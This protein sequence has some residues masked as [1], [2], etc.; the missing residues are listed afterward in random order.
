MK[1]IKLFSIIVI[2]IFANGILKAQTEIPPELL[3]IFMPA[4][5]S[6]IDTNTTD[7]MA[8]VSPYCPRLSPWYTDSS[9]FMINPNSIE[10][11]VGVNFFIFQKNDG[12]ANFQEDDT[13]HIKIFQDIEIALNNRFKNLRQLCGLVNTDTKIRFVCTPIFVRNSD[14]WKGK[15]RH[16]WAQAFEATPGSPNG[17]NV[18]FFMHEDAY[19]KNVI[20]NDSIKHWEKEWNTL[21]PSTT[22][23]NVPYLYINAPN[24]FVK[25]H[26]MKNWATVQYG[27][28]WN[29][30]IYGWFID[31]TVKGL[32]HELG[33][34]F[35][36]RNN[37][38]PQNY[39][40]SANIMNPVG[41]SSHD[42]LSDWEISIIHR[43]F[44]VTTARKYVHDQTTLDAPLV[45]TDSKFID[46]DVRL[47]RDIVIESGAQL[48][49][50]CKVLMP[51]SGRIIIHPGGKLIVDGG[52]L[53]NACSDKLWQGIYISGNADMPQTA[54]Y[55]GV[56]VLSLL[57]MKIFLPPT[58]LLLERTLP[59]GEFWACK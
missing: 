26:W 39:C 4:S 8:Q 54:Q 25:Y 38:V 13:E 40:D 27:L 36:I 31:G 41:S 3:E 56:T 7:G 5:G 28:P 58:T 16:L 29:P 1:S 47:Y 15:E 46:F 9:F 22:F 51:S 33:H 10:K 50:T 42:Y 11:I 34:C 6:T 49:I 24:L 30:A 12:S 32:A 45:I 53:T 35:N 2:M 59:C 21:P 18:L 48:T 44:A 20:E 55:Q 23:F 37:I 57:T 17:I 43:A 52:I 19:V 14:L